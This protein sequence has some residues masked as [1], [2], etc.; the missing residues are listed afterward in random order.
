M[1]AIFRNIILLALTLALA[2]ACS[3]QKEES[4]SGDRTRISLSPKPVDFLAN[5]IT[6]EGELRFE[7]VVTVLEGSSIS[8]Q[9]WTAEVVDAPAWVE[10]ESHISIEREFY[11]HFSGK[12]H[13][14]HEKG[15]SLGCAANAGYSRYFVLRITADDGTAVDFRFRQDG[16]FEDA[17]VHVDKTSVELL[18]NDNSPLVI[19]Y[20]SNAGGLREVSTD[21]DWLHATIDDAAVTIT[22]DDNSSESEAREGHVK[23]KVGSVETSVDSVIITVTQLAKTLQCFVFG[24]ALKGHGTIADGL[25]M[26]AVEKNV[27]F[28]AKG[29]FR[30]SSGYS[31]QIS[32]RN[33]EGSWPLYALA[34][35]GVLV[36]RNSS[37][38]PLP[39]CNDLDTDGMKEIG[40][41]L[42]TLTWSVERV[43]T[44]NCMPDSEIAN[45]T[46]RAYTAENGGSKVWLTEALHWDGGPGIGTYKLGSGLVE[47]AATG[48]YGAKDW[49]VRNPAYDTE[50]NGG[51]LK[52][53]MM[54]DGVT[55]RASVYGRLYSAD[56]I[57]TGEPGGA[58][59]PYYNG[60]RPYGQ[61][62][63]VVTDAVGNV[64]TLEIVTKETIQKYARTAVGNAK[65]EVD[66]PQIVMQLQGICPYGWHIANLQDW[67]DMFYAEVKYG[68]T[69]SVQIAAE[70]AS[71]SAMADGASE[72]CDTYLRSP[73]WANDEFKRSNGSTATVYTEAEDF[74][75]CIYPNGWRLLSTGYDRCANSQNPYHFEIIPMLGK[76][77]DHTWRIYCDWAAKMMVNDAHAMANVSGQCVRCVKNYEN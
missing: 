4:P 7:A 52:E 11:D 56:E 5:G 71:Y 25:R 44:P 38:D 8:S 63:T 26:T 41:N 59:N 22:A 40:I 33:S 54:P 28:I 1:K 20:V 31:L 57:F 72:K 32:N 75:I 42:S 37:A 12:T 66:H 69:H 2:G 24:P 15:V 34:D 76:S 13:T 18:S 39:V 23:I 55:T 9:G 16:V 19:P 49:T 61:D 51:T 3:A 60:L 14:S 43:S 6:S 77:S 58:L 73:L 45:Y 21:R 50:E 65:A 17:S 64:Y 46:Q 62:G 53:L 10:F 27:A 67:K 68:E 36:V 48:G 70:Q 30:T 35:G 47:G 29:Y 74:G